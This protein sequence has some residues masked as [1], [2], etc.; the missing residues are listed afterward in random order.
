MSGNAVRADGFGATVKNLCIMRARVMGHLKRRL[1]PENPRLTFR[2]HLLLFQLWIAG[3]EFV[4]AA[5]NISNG[6]A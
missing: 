5:A 2:P 4:Q 3:L 6:L 1:F